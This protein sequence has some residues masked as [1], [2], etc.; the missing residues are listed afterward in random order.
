M[1]IIMG[2]A[3]L[4]LPNIL[5]YSLFEV[6]L[7]T[8]RITETA[9]HN[10]AVDRSEPYC[11][12]Y[13]HLPLGLVDGT[14]WVPGR[15]SDGEYDNTETESWIV[16][17]LTTATQYYCTLSTRQMKLLLGKHEDFDC[18]RAKTCT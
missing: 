6:G 2:I 10:T 12:R 16:R 5:V 15:P 14:V 1:Y 18:L 8:V 13:G 11:I 17:T 4:E 3:F 9:V 7:C